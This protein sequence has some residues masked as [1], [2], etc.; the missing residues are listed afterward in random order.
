MR[1]P[2]VAKKVEP[3]R[4][5]SC[6]HADQNVAMCCGCYLNRCDRKKCADEHAACFTPDDLVA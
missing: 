3:E 1:R 2:A 6:G 5:D 4:C